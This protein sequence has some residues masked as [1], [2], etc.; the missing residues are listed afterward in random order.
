V[1]SIAANGPTPPEGSVKKLL[2]LAATAALMTAC[3]NAPTA[4]ERTLAPGGR[5]SADLSCAS[6]YIIAYDEN[7]NPYCAPDPNARMAPTRPKRP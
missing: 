6:G 7:G 2:L 3:S 1:L 5:A 4:P